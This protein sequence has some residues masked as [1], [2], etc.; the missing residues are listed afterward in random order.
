MI[1]PI[2]LSIS[3][4]LIRLVGNKVLLGRIL[5]L[6]TGNRYNWSISFLRYYFHTKFL[7]SSDYL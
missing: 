3:D 2:S 1:L 6:D 7:I 5:L 4:R